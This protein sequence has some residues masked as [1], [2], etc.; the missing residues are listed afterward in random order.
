MPHLRSPHLKI[1][2]LR[3][4][5]KARVSNSRKKL[6]LI[7]KSRSPVRPKAPGSKDLTLT[8]WSIKSLT[9]SSKEM[10]WLTP[11]IRRRDY[12]SWGCSTPVHT[13]KQAVLRGNP[14]IKSYLAWLWQALNCLIPTVLLRKLLLKCLSVCSGKTSVPGKR[15]VPLSLNPFLL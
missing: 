4:C 8:C 12:A 10:L 5:R 7:F 6:K 2:S 15:S 11:K 1:K 13:V 3:R 9:L 14:Y